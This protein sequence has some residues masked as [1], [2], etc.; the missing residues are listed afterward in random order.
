MAMK[1]KSLLKL[2]IISIFSALVFVGF[3]GYVI[4]G[5]SA[6]RTENILQNSPLNIIARGQEV[7]IN[8]EKI[9]LPWIQW[10]DRDNQTHTGVADLAAEA[11]LGMELKSSSNPNSQPIHWFNFTDTLPTVFVNPYRYL[12]ITNI[13]RITPLTME[14]TLDSL[15]LNL[16]QSQVNKVY[17]I[18]ENQEQKVIIELGQPSFF[19]VS[20]GRDKAVITINSPPDKSILTPVLSPDN[21]NIQ[22]EEGDEKR[23]AEGENKPLFTVT[24]NNNKSIVEINLPPFNQVRVTSANPSFLIID[25]KP[26]AVSPREIRWR[27]NLVFNRRYVGINNNADSFLVSSL[28]LNIKDF[29]LDMRPILPNNN[30][31]MGTAPL[32][33]IAQNAEAMAGINGGFFN[34]N[35]QLPLGAIKDRDNWL[36]SPILNRGVIGWNNL[37]EVIISRLQL[38]EVIT[39]P[40]GDRIINNYLN[41]GYIQAGIARYTEHWGRSYTTLSD[42]EIILTVENREVKDKLVGVKAGQDTV[43]IVPKSYLLVFRKS[44]TMAEKLVQGDKITLNTYTYPM[45]INQYPQ[46]MGAGPLL[47]LNNQIVLDGE[48]EKFSQAF[49]NQ[50]AS[51]SAIALDSQGRIILMAVHN[52]IG[53]GGASLMELAQILKNMGAVS[54]L[55]LDGGSSTQIYLGGAIIDR[56]P[57]TAARVHNGI[58]VFFRER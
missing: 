40:R 32:R 58:G 13:G 22:E 47:L 12:D 55:N 30:T 37:G 10:Q 20:Q 42:D 57:A 38:E 3:N 41:S 7:V 39:T 35:N 18:K 15:S 51:R 45:D 27:D 1:K 52:R 49:N 31:V 34:R 19:Q 48:G 9:N 4:S 44:K 11:L 2:V 33:N 50:K 5:A 17:S 16:P 28:T 46:I 53:G 23:K 8:Q 14:K 54:A 24:T 25:I 26:S 43:A 56:S 6:Q 29:S 21:T 36:S